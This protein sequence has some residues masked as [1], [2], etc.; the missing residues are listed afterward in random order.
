MKRDK[1]WREMTLGL[2]R[3]AQVLAALA[4]PERQFRSIHIGGTNGKGSVSWKVADGLQCAGKRVGLYTSPHLLTPYERVRIGGIPL[5]AEKWN[6]FGQEVDRCAKKLGLQLSPF[7]GWTALA[8]LAFAEAAVEWVVCEVGLGGRLDAT[9]VL[10]PELAIITSIGLDH[11]EWLGHDLRTIARE[12]GG[13]IKANVPLLLGPR[14]RG[15]GLEEQAA[16]IGAPLHRVEEDSADYLEENHAIACTALSLLSFSFPLRKE[17][18]PPGRFHTLTLPG[19][20][21]LIYDV[22]HNP[23]GIDAFFQTLQLRRPGC[24][25]RLA[26]G[27]NQHK[28]LPRLFARTFQ[29]GFPLHLITGEAPLAPYAKL[30]RMAAE[31]GGKVEPEGGELPPLF[32]TLVAKARER[33]EGLVVLGSHALALPL[34]QGLAPICH[35]TLS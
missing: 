24:T 14:A 27:W 19:S 10:H 28:N 21:E 16:Q 15:F 25:W 7:E 9:N 1:E 6:S 34:E 35:L 20:V 2:D 30:L 23:A 17:V 3:M 22:A 4:H 11:E 32:P 5:S 13:I 31:V 8:F 18:R 12:K 26:V 29:T 33:G